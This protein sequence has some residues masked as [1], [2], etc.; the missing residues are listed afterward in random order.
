MLAFGLLAGIL[1]ARSTGE[2]QVID[3]AML[4]GAALLTA[5]AR[6]MLANEMWREERGVNV[7][8]GGAPYYAT[9]ETSDRKWIAVGALEDEFYATLLGKLG[10][11]GDPMLARR[12][13]P[14]LWS[15]QG[16][17]L[18]ALFRTRTRDEWCALLGECDA[19]FAPVLT[20]VEAPEHPHNRSRGTFVEIDGL[21]QPAPAPRF[22]RTP[23]PPIR[24]K[25]G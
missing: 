12:S 6:A 13:D 17:R 10:L 19:C 1:S 11:D 3:C 21:I 9:Y 18:A 15:E 24:S 23:A 5:Q 25:Q 20:M 22:S 8:D 16:R 14:A 7:L 4:D 2:G